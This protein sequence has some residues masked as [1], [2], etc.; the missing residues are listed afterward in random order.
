MNT[1]ELGEEIEGASIARHHRL[2]VATL[3]LA[4]LFDGYN[5]F[6]PAYVIPYVG[7]WHLRPSEAGLLVSSGLVGFM[8]G[9]LASGVLADRVGRKPTL[10]GALWFACAANLATALWGDSFGRFLLLRLVTGLG[11]GMILPVSVTLVNELAPRRRVNVLVG[12]MM[13]GWS[14]GGVAAA[15]LAL[16]LIPT[17]G[18]PAL[19]AAGAIAAPAIALI[20]LALPESPRFLAARGR[21]TAL[22]A[23]MARLVPAR[24]GAYAHVKFSSP[25]ASGRPGSLA[26]LLSPPYRRG[27]LILWVCSALSLFTIF[28]LSSWIPDILLRRGL[29]VGASFSL[30]AWLQLTALHGGQGSR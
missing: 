8:L 13:T 19:F 30:A 2:V 12:W 15:L 29:P 25:A 4:T 16:A 28:G 21:D 20:A 17:R 11:L 14:I 7:S 9:A 10:I 22:R 6:V 18:W 1:L 5:V 23:V 26:R 24:A 3:A 27:T